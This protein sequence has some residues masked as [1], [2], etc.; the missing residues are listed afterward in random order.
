MMESP[1]A[2]AN[3][4]CGAGTGADAPVQPRPPRSAIGPFGLAT[5]RFVWLL[6]V[7]I[8]STCAFAGTPSAR[9]VDFDGNGVDELAVWRPSNGTWHVRDRVSGFTRTQ[10]PGWQWGSG[11][12]VPVPGNYDGGA[13]L[14]FWRPSNGTWYVKDP[15]DWDTYSRQFGLP[16]DIPVP[17]IYLPDGTTD[18]AVWRPSD[19]TWHRL[20]G[21]VD[22]SRQWG[23][24]G[25]VPVPGD[26]DGDYEADYAVWRPSNGTW[27]VI[28][29]AGMKRNPR[30]WGLQGDQ[31]VPGDYDGDG[32]MD[33]A[34]WRPSD[35]TWHVIYSSNGSEHDGPQWGLPGDIPVPAQIDNDLKTDFAVWRP[36][37]G[38]WHH[39]F[40]GRDKAPHSV[41]VAG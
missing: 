28:S 30:Q 41:R 17:Y 16:G 33:F 14:A 10:Q 38:T 32:T 19:Q 37:D 36:S 9:A 24:P 7:L 13:E 15:F 22:V 31:P 2:T 27:Y 21:G 8:V 25:D 35:G 1:L 11:N 4:T 26:Y 5:H 40:L 20:N 23:L 3:G 29:L 34:V 18:F 39:Q 12:D 6:A